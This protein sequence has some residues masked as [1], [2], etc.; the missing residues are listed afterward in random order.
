MWQKVPA[1]IT[2]QRCSATISMAG[3]IC[4]SMKLA[5]MIMSV[6][7]AILFRDMSISRLQRPTVLYDPSFSN[8]IQLVE[9][10]LPSNSS[11]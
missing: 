10:T 5:V 11:S 1:E 9:N 8:R 4:S 7:F 3:I 2:K 6:I